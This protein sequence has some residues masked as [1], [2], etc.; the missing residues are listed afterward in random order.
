M[1][2]FFMKSL[3][4]SK[5]KGA[6]VPESEIEKLLAVVEENPD[7]F[8]SMAEKV[9]AKVAGGM[10]QEAAIAEILGSGNEEFKKILNKDIKKHQQ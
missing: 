6:G 2:N 8:K 1:M 3:L 10:T 7:F 9:Q 4:K 5:L